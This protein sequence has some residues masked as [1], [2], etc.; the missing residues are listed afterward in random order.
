MALIR[1]CFLLSP[2]LGDYARH[3][4]SEERRTLEGNYHKTEQLMSQTSSNYSLVL[5]AVGK[6]YILEKM[7]PCG[8][9]SWTSMR[10]CATRPALPLVCDPETSA[11]GSCELHIASC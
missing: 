2:E 11:E 7:N 4:H 6:N 10:D 8:T 5:C 9:A 1:V 3:L